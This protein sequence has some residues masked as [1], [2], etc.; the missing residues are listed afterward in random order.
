M[1]ELM[2]AANVLICVIGWSYLMYKLGERF[3]RHG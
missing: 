3:G 2:L 1:T